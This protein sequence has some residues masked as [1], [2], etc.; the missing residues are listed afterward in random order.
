[1]RHPTEEHFVFHVDIIDDVVD[2]VDICT[3]L[4]F[5]FSDFYDFDFGSFDYACDYSAVV[6]S[7]CVEISF[8]IHSNCDAGAGP[9]PRISLPPT[10][11]LP[12]PSPIQAPSL[13]LKRLA[14]HLKY[15]YLDY[16]Q[17]LLVI[18]SAA[19]H[20]SMRISCCMF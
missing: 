15:A 9:D 4:L 16:A 8:S 5:N 1:M 14:K 7:I 2:G 17:K 19:F 20:L 10:I 11:N 6:C 13:E 12:L 3:N 18:I